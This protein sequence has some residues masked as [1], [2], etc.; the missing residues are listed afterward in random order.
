MCKYLEN[1][2]EVA[3]IL[4]YSSR[5]LHQAVSEQ[6]FRHSGVVNGLVHGILVPRL[7][8]NDTNVLYIGIPCDVCKYLEDIIEVALIL[9]YNQVY[10]CLADWSNQEFGR[11]GGG[12]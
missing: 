4:F 11:S 8:L 12:E 6:D 7:F 1:I 9:F 3:L 2:I 5:Y 10:L